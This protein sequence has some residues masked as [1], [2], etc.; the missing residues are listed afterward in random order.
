MSSTKDSSATVMQQSTS[1]TS[2]KKGSAMASAS[3]TQIDPN[4]NC[5]CVTFVWL[6]HR[7]DSTGSF[8]GALRAIN[9]HVRMF[10]ETPTCLDLIKSSNEKIFFISSSSNSEFL[11]TVNL[12]EAVEAIFVFDP[13]TS[14]IRGDFPKLVNIFTQQEELLRALRTTLDAFEHLQLEAFAFETDKVFLW[15]Q[16]WKEEVSFFS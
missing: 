8:V 15:W 7:R 3:T 12:C 10:T 2:S 4:V 13:D 16:I 9:D 14:S 6:D 1:M 11:A 5:E